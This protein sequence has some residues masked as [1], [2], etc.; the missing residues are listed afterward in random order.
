MFLEN[1][2]VKALSFQKCIMLKSINI[3]N[4]RQTKKLVK[5]IALKTSEVTG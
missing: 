1:N 2:F 5:E 3:I 4:N